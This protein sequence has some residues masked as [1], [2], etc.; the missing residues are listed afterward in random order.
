MAVDNA[1]DCTGSASSG[2]TEG[3]A[4]EITVTFTWMPAAGQTMATDPPPMAVVVALSGD[5]YAYAYVFGGGASTTS[6]DDGLGDPDV[7]GMNTSTSSGIHHF[8]ISGNT[9]L[10]TVTE[11]A[12]P[13]VLTTMSGGGSG[14]SMVYFDLSA[15]IWPETLQFTGG[16]GPGTAYGGQ[17]YLIGQLLGAYLQTG[18]GIPGSEL[19]V[20]APNWYSWSPPSG[21]AP[22]ANFTTNPTPQD[23]SGSAASNYVPL[24]ALSS[25]TLSCYFAQ[26]GTVSITV[27][28]TFDFPDGVFP[29]TLSGQ[30][31]VIPPAMSV[32]TNMGTTGLMGGDMSGDSVGLYNAAYPA[33][34]PGLPQACG[35]YWFGTVT[36]PPEFVTANETGFWSVA[37]LFT[38]NLGETKLG[39]QYDQFWQPTAPAQAIDITFPT[40]LQG[41]DT[42][43]PYA[44]RWFL[45]DGTQGGNGDAPAY[46]FSSVFDMSGGNNFSDTIMYVTARRFQRCGS[47]W[48][49][50][51]QLGSATAVHSVNNQGVVVW[52]VTNMTQTGAPVNQNVFN[53]WP[54]W[55]RR[56]S[57][58]GGG[59]MPNIIFAP[60]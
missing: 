39:E 6:A 13:N 23:A 50:L 59:L 44:G 19:Q 33:D 22:F 1:G 26:P 35:I 17:Q 20:V 54:S 57:V 30:V 55:T 21:G 40:L 41:L 42:E 18:L 43:Y 51:I 32:T 28:Y 38:T 34:I 27:T 60:R 16:I 58:L 46:F 5:A 7:P 53:V 2:T 11:T 4:G 12:T 56:Y 49:L 31:G 25:G 52:T 29:V 24:T 3:I 47:D 10:A 48:Q 9:P 15:N 14:F 36:T 37:Q 45:A 8:T